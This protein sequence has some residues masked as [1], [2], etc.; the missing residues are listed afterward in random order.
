MT[1]AVRIVYTFH[2]GQ[3]VSK[4]VALAFDPATFTLIV[5]DDP[6]PAWAALGFATCGHCPLNDVPFC[7]FARALAPIVPSFVDF[8][9]YHDAVVEV[10]TPRRTVVAK[11]AVQEGTASVIGLVGATAGCPHLDFFRPMARF[12][13]PFATEEETL[14]RLFSMYLLG[15]RVRGEPVGL[16]GLKAKSTAVARVNAGMAERLRAGL[17]RDALVNG[18]I[19]LDTFAQAAAYVM[20][21]QMA[22]L[23]YIF[24]E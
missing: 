18:L 16:D 1:A 13:L 21:K 4:Q 20:D 9:S 11:G 24:A 17:S 14:V 8:Y 2:L 22:D 12:H 15:C 7:P 3:G 23:R 5:A 6:P 10:V 19:I